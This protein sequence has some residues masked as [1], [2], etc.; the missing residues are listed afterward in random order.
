LNLQS[1]AGLLDA[2][3]DE[4]LEPESLIVPT[5][6]RGFSILPAGRPVASTA[7]LLSSKRM[8]KIVSA[9]CAYDPRRIVLLDSPPL[10]VTNEGRALLKLAG[11]V[12]LVVRAGRTPRPAVQAAVALFDPQQAGGMVLNEVRGSAGEGYYEYGTY[13]S[14]ADEP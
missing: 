13:G 9:L 14:V 1:S 7:E 2:L 8:R 5:T 10:L 11:Q 4:T 12:V 3:V 6:T